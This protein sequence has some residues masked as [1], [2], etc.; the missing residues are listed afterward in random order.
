MNRNYVGQVA[1]TGPKKTSPLIWSW[2]N[3]WRL[4]K[5]QEIGNKIAK[6]LRLNKSLSIYEEEYVNKWTE[7]Y[8]YDMDVIELAL[9]MT[10]GKAQF[11]YIDSI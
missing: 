11:R 7:Q 9:K 4:I 2:K 1:P 5:G 6:A 10:V 3:I 8:G